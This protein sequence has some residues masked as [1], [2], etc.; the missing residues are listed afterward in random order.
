MST[1][2]LLLLVVVGFF[3]SSPGG[4]VVF[5]AFAFSCANPLFLPNKITGSPRFSDLKRE[6]L[7]GAGSEDKG[8][9]GH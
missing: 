5:V 6:C 9:T 7:G 3:Y 4:S 2:F 8:E 1:L